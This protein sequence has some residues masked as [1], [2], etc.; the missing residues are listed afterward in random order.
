MAQ[1]FLTCTR[2]QYEEL[3]YISVFIRNIYLGVGMGKLICSLFKL[4]YK[5]MILRKQM[6]VLFSDG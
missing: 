6:G 3:I 5:K 2:K 1:N 4:R